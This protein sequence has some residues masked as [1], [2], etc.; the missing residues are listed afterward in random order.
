MT[1]RIDMLLE[2]SEQ[3][4]DDPFTK[5]LLAL[6]YIKAEKIT[7]ARKWMENIYTHHSDYLPNY[8]HYAKLLEHAGDRETAIVVCRKGMIIAKEQKDIHTYSELQGALEQIEE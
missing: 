1:S 6:E 8:Y 7:E 4:P 3:S 5:Y 2:Y